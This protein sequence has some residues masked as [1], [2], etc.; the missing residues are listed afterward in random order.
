MTELDKEFLI[1]CCLH[2]AKQ[3]RCW[4][5]ENPK[6]VWELINS[7]YVYWGGNRLAIT[8]KGEELYQILYKK[9]VR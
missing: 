7:G 3:N 8:P 2:A 1:Q 6:V 4:N 5:G 9:V